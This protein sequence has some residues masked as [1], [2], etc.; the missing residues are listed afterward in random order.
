MELERT[1][2]KDLLQLIRYTYAWS[3]QWK[4]VRGMS[5]TMSKYCRM[6]WFW[7]WTTRWRSIKSRIMP[8]FQIRMY[9]KIWLAYWLLLSQK[10]WRTE[11]KIGILHSRWSSKLKPGQNKWMQNS[12]ISSDMHSNLRL[13]MEWS[14][15]AIKNTWIMHSKIFGW[16]IRNKKCLLSKDNISTMYR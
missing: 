14:W 4:I 5:V 12:N 8:S 9:Y 16:I 7:C 13:P 1:C 15:S 3:Q 11:Q 6:Y 10:Y 2:D